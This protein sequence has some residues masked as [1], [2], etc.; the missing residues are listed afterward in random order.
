MKILF[1]QIEDYFS[2]SSAAEGSR[3]LLNGFLENGYEVDFVT[4]NTIHKLPIHPKLRFV[5]LSQ[6]SLNNKKSIF[7]KF[8]HLLRKLYYKFSFLDQFIVMKFT[9]INY[10]NFFNKYDYV[11]SVSDPKSTHYLFLKFLKSNPLKYDKWIQYWGDP[12]LNDMTLKLITPKFL[13]R[14][15]ERN[16][17]QKADFVY[18]NSPITYDLQVKT[19]K[20]ISNRFRFVPTPSNTF[21]D[22]KISKLPFIHRIGY[23]G[24]YYSSIRNIIPF[25]NFI[26]SKPQLNLEIAGSS[27]LKLKNHANITVHPLLERTHLETLLDNVDTILVVLN[28]FGPQLPSKIFHNFYSKKNII[29]LFESDNYY[30]MKL[31]LS[32]FDRFHLI[33]NNQVSIENYFDNYFKNFDSKNFSY[34]SI[35]L[36]PKFIS[37]LILNTK[38]YYDEVN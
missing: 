37:S 5:Q 7:S 17:L 22:T 6:I 20:N 19:Y 9:K 29:I 27:D 23:F 3:L 24:S 1:F 36:T 28:L 16:I 33:Y 31:Y 30:F 34:S 10:F 21:S 25:Y 38:S 26:K 4:R 18:Y 13:V 2:K 14:Y 35:N 32:S 8:T 15:F 11:F 12:I